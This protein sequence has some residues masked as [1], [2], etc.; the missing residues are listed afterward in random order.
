MSL[1]AVLDRYGFLTATLLL[2]SGFKFS[3]LEMS[4]SQL[5]NHALSRNSTHGGS[6][7]VLLSVLISSFRFSLT[8]K[9]LVWNNS[10]ITY[11]TVGTVSLKSE[12]PLL[13]ER[14]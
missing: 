12:L 1:P 10:A 9:P 14:L 3:Q 7:E 5:V 4:Q 2:H 8:G 11:P 13:V 6:A